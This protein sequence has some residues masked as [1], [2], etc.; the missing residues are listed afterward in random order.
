MEKKLVTK[1]LEVGI[2]IVFLVLRN[3][4]MKDKRYVI[5]RDVIKMSR[6]LT[7]LIYSGLYEVAFYKNL[8]CKKI[9]I[10]TE[11]LLQFH[12]HSKNG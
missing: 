10:E 11:A 5:S 1:L 2:F 3:L 9:D 4:L 7:D 6:T 12:S 8:N